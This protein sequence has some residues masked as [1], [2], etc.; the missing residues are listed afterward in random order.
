MRVLFIETFYGGSH[1]T[2]ADQ[3]AEASRNEIHLITLPPRFWK[4]RQAGSA[5]RLSQ[6]IP[7]KADTLFDVVIAGGMLDLAHLKVLRPDLPPVLLYLHENQFDYPLGPGEKIDF[8]YG[9]VDVMNILASDKAAFNSSYNRNSLM[10]EC[11]KLF[12]RLPDAIP[13]D[14]PAKLEEKSTVLYPGIAPMTGTQDRNA[15]R[16]ER[17][18][19]LVIWNHRH[20]HDKNPEAAFDALI[21]LARRSVRFEL[22]ILGENFSNEPEAFNR[23]RRHLS[24][25]IVFDG[26]PERIRYNEWLYKGSVVISTA[27]QENFGL[28]VIEAAAAGCWPLMP[29]RL[30]YPEV[31][32]QW[33]SGACFWDDG[34]SLDAK[35]EK[36]LRLSDS[37]RRKLTSPLSSWMKT[38]E[39][40][41]RAPLID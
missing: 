40:T 10:T 2:F 15:R 11:G 23:A 38:Y 25:Q 39:W 3:Y 6:L 16:Q 21:R 5:M 1:K 9:L 24:K 28:S 35:L 30:A 19:P 14:V 13:S 17:K 37:E 12:K 27:M 31:M 34:P 41:V 22:A 20:E 29:R 36:V 33:V 8:R 26:Y 32:P 7:P 18:I 4:W